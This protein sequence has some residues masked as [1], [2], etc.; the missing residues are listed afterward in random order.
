[1]PV[2]YVG[3][4]SRYHLDLALS[5]GFRHIMVTHPQVL[6]EVPRLLREGVDVIVD[7]GAYYLGRADIRMT[8]F[9]RQVGAKYIMP[10]VVGDARATLDLHLR[11]AHLYEPSLAFCVLQ[12]SRLEEYLWCLHQ[13]ARRFSPRQVAIGGLL[14]LPLRRRLSVLLSVRARFRGWIHALGLPNPVTDSYDITMRARWWETFGPEHIR[15]VEERVA[16]ELLR[17]ME[18]APILFGDWEAFLE[19]VRRERPLTRRYRVVVVGPTELRVL[20]R[21]GRGYL[22]Q[23]MRFK[24]PLSAEVAFN[25]ICRAFEEHGFTWVD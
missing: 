4:W 24:D 2:V 13:M 10:D 12:G 11:Y 22:R 17:Y 21:A 19:W 20:A 23:R 5:H 18:V 9:A 14:R 8:S 6:P 1:M 3:V 15:R 16:S 25:E 7:N